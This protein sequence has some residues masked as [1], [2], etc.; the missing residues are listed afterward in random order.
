[1]DI[2]VA[3]NNSHKGRELSAIFAGHAIMTPAEIG[4]TFDFE[5]DGL[6]FLENALGKAR[7]LA[8]LTSQAVVVADDSGLCLNG[9]D[10]RPGVRSARYGSPDGGRTEL[11][12]SARNELLLGELGDNPDRSAFFVCCMVAVFPDERFA[13]AQETLEGRIARRQSG[14]GGFGYDPLFYLPGHGCTVAELPESEKNR[15]SHRGKAARALWGA[16]EIMLDRLP[17]RP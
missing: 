5:E 12:S 13:V 2:L 6:T 1:M 10:G 14:T 4:I 7:A 17:E 8:A 9:L 11:D 15:I 3:T 16:V